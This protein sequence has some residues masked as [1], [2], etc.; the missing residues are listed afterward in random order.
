MLQ[1]SGMVLKFDGV[2]S[3]GYLV[4]LVGC[5]CYLFLTSFLL[6]SLSIVNFI[7]DI[8]LHYDIENPW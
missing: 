4:T 2:V 5:G 6:L 3:L 1:I 7:Y 8:D